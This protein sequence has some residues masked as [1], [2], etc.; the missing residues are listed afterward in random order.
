MTSLRHEAQDFFRGLRDRI[1]ARLEE[2]DGGQFK[3]TRWERPGGG[4]G[5]MS[6]LRGEVFE[7]GGCN[8]SAVWGDKYPAVVDASTSPAA[9]KSRE[10][11]SRLGIQ[12]PTPAELAGKPFFATGVSLVLHP[13]NPFVPVVHMNVRMPAL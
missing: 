7:K 9:S 12:P 5:E 13:R 1:C 2:L 11:D 3:R 6:E 10:D 4:G 8:F